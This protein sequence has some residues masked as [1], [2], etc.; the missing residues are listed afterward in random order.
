MNK[1]VRSKFITIFV[2]LVIIPISIF[3]TLLSFIIHKKNTHNF[4]ITQTSFLQTIKFNAIDTYIDKV[5]ELVFALSNSE[6][7]TE[8]FDNPD[9]KNHKIKEW[10]FFRIVFP[11]ISWMYYCDS[12]K[13][14][15]IVSPEWIASEGYSIYNRPWYITG[16]ESET[17]Q[18]TSPYEEYI[19]K[20]IVISA[21]RG[22]KN[23]NGVYKGV[24]S[25]DLSLNKILSQIAYESTKINIDLLVLQKNKLSIITHNDNTIGIVNDLNIL[26]ESKTG[27]TIKIN[28]KRY[29]VVILPVKK[30]GINLIS[31]IPVTNINQEGISIFYIIFCVAV[32]ALLTAVLMGFYISKQLI[33]KIE[34]LGKYIQKKIDGDYTQELIFS[35]DDEFSVVN[36]NFNYLLKLIS[37]QTESLEN[38]NKSLHEQLLLKE[39]LVDLRNSLLHILTHNSASPI[40]YLFHTT[41]QLSDENP[42]DQRYQT[43][44]Q[45]S[46]DLKKFNENIMAYLK[47][48]SGFTNCLSER[49]GITE[50]TGLIINNCKKYCTIK[51]ISI[52]MESDGDYFIYGDYFLTKIILENLIDNAIKYTFKEGHISILITQN[53]QY[54]EWHIRDSGPGFSENDKEKMFTKFQKLSAKPTGMEQSTG[55]GL[56]LVKKI[57]EIT[58]ATLILDN[59]SNSCGA[60]FII[61]FN[62]TSIKEID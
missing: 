18:W 20:D 6:D 26:S 19:T 5:E 51:Q 2:L 58:G 9:I 47:V 60:G 4:I 39:Q 38:H 27:D 32:F 8:I 13:N 56:Y 29:Y 46:R 44:H 37:H 34:L 28:K 61:R 15:I 31:L 7:V 22:V 35:S 1:T 3:S 24:F 14:K 30:I 23:S 45:A 49:I 57:S 12:K 21:S 59:S 50:L 10:N 36:T 52:T 40:T 53:N 43:V 48:D 25:I 33:S 62:R 17:V 55:L 41:N 16:K 11:E 42:F 54:V